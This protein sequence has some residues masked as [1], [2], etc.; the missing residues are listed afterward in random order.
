MA[1]ATTSRR[2]DFIPGHG[3]FRPPSPAASSWQVGNNSRES[4]AHNLVPCTPPSTSRDR[5]APA[6][7]LQP[8]RY[9]ASQVRQPSGRPHRLAASTR[10]IHEV[11]GDEMQL[12]GT[13][14]GS[15]ERQLEMSGE[16]HD[17]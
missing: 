1:G 16:V 2:T 4:K 7:G 13:P 5:E 10:N 9:T 17:L 12:D 11:L 6:A 3:M 8:T 15:L 14:T